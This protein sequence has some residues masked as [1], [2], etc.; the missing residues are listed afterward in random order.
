MQFE[1]NGTPYFLTFHED[2]GGWLL[3]TPA[4]QGLRRLAI[5]DDGGPP[6]VPVEW[7]GFNPGERQP[8]N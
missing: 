2:A 6:A 8:L 7:E 1:V 5:V 3:L 4:G